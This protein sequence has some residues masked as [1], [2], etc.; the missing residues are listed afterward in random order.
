MPTTFGDVC[1]C[2]RSNSGKKKE[3]RKIVG[4]RSR[5]TL[6]IG[7]LKIERM[8][9]IFSG[10]AVNVHYL[11]VKNAVAICAILKKYIYV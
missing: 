2:F 4:F 9:R 10:N 3:E 1:V 5:Q 11:H 7:D 6:V 8:S